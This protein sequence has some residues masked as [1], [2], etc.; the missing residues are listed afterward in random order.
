VNIQR[1]I[2]RIDPDGNIDALA[3]APA[4]TLYA[5]TAIAFG[6]GWEL[7]NR[8]SLPTSPSLDSAVGF[9]AW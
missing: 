3:A 7:E 9:P 8:S 2:V 1:K 5:P 4:D 6:T